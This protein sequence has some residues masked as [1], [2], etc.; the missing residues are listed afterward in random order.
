MQPAALVR[1]LLAC[2]DMVG[3]ATLKLN[4][5]RGK[6][7]SLTLKP[8]MRTSDYASGQQLLCNGVGIGPLP[9]LIARQSLARGELVPV[10][11]D[12]QVATGTLYA[13]TLSGAQAPAR[14]RLFREFLRKEL[15][16]LQQP[17]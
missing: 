15:A 5:G 9:D 11:A 16:T 3:A 13:I 6:E 1:Q 17:T 14:V 4:D 2:R 10:L 8:V 7:T 12:W